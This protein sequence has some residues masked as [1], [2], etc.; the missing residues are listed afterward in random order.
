MRNDLRNKDLLQKFMSSRPDLPGENIRNVKAPNESIPQP[1]TDSLYRQG[2]A[3]VEANPPKMVGQNVAAGLGGIAALYGAEQ[4]LNVGNLNE[5]EDAA[6]AEYKRINSP[7]NIAAFRSNNDMLGLGN[8]SYS[9]RDQNKIIEEDLRQKALAQE[10]ANMAIKDNIVDPS[11]MSVSE[12]ARVKEEQDKYLNSATPDAL[13]QPPTEED[14][15]TRAQNLINNLGIDD[16]VQKKSV[17]DNFLDAL[18]YFAPTIGAGLIGTAIGGVE[19]GY[20]S[21]T[22][23]HKMSKDYAEFVQNQNKNQGLTA[24]DKLNA[25]LRLGD[26]AIANRRTDLAYSKE[27]NMAPIRERKMI[28]TEKSLELRKQLGIGNL[29]LNKENLEYKKML[30]SQLSDAQVKEFGESR[31]GLMETEELIKFADTNPRMKNLIGTVK[32]RTNSMASLV[33]AAPKEYTYLAGK[34]ADFSSAEYHRRFGAAISKQ[35][36]ESL[37]KALPTENDSVD[38]F[39]IKMKAFNQNLKDKLKEKVNTIKAGQPLRGE[40]AAKASGIDT[41]GIKTVGGV[42]YKKVQGGWERVE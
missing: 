31:E 23:A 9:L 17:A 6:L 15:L 33:N 25:A 2:K 7:E 10:S 13:E 40:S 4:A 36:M 12:Q 11:E 21:A 3:T 29:D 24:K 20:A 41:T 8:N 14:A 37:Q 38:T 32:G 39:L 5:G 1:S 19:S 22:A 34:L 16:G 42:K 30:G 26:Q 35:E 28:S 18:T 27:E